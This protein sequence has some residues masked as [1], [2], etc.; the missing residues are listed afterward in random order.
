MRM[1][2]YGKE[3]RTKLRINTESVVGEEGFDRDLSMR[4]RFGGILN[5]KRLKKRMVNKNTMY[6]SHTLRMD[7][8]P[9]AR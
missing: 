4:S 2:F 3:K 9:S 5:T 8:E 1:T 7:R 6:L